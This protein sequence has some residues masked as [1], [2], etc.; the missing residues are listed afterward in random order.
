MRIKSVESQ[1]AEADIKDYRFCFLLSDPCNKAE[2]VGGSLS[3][4]LMTS[5]FLSVAI[6]SLHLRSSLTYL[7]RHPPILPS[8]QMICHS[9][10]LLNY[11]PFYFLAS[12][13]QPTEISCLANQILLKQINVS[14]LDAS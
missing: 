4:Y 7:P 10:T 6:I 1:Q 11:R 9:L 2:W 13:I 12:P 14:A 3:Y 5:L 8:N